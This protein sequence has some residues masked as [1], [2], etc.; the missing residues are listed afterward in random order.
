M[1]L[2]A[3]MWARLDEGHWLFHPVLSVVIEMTL[4]ALHDVPY[5]DVLLLLRLCPEGI[6]VRELVSPGS[7]T[8]PRSREAMSVRRDGDP[9]AAW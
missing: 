6:Y 9:I 1:P 2:M 7:C 3:I 4:G 5:R 8:Y